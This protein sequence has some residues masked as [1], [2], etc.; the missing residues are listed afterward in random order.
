M[1]T[2]STLPQPVPDYDFTNNWFGSVAKGVWDSLIPQLKPANAL[3]I[4]SYEGASACYLIEKNNRCEVL[5]ICCVDTWAGGV[6]HQ[7]MAVDMNAVEAR[8]DHNVGVARARA[9][10]GTVL[11]KQKGASDQVLAELITEGHSGTFD[12]V[13]VDGSHQAPDVLTDV[14]LAFKL[15]K[16]GGVIAFDDY[17]RA[18]KLNYGKDPIRFPK[19]AD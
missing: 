12:F 8:F 2:A 9:A 13:Y 4:G 15:C 6:E 16:V 17:L 5:Q 1:L 14:V 18:E 7:A 11:N 19:I 3:E 10:N